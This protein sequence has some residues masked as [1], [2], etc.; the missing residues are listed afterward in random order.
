MKQL[1]FL[2]P[3]FK[4]H[5]ITEALN[6][7][8]SNY[9]QLAKFL[10]R[11]TLCT[12]QN[13]G[14]S[15]EQ[16]LQNLLGLEEASFPQAALEGLYQKKIQ[17]ED[18]V[19]YISADFVRFNADANHVFLE[20]A[21]NTS[22]EVVTLI[23]TLCD[24]VLTLVYES[25]YRC[26][27]RVNQILDVLFN[28]IWE[29]VGRSLH[30]RLP[31]GPDAGLINRLS[32]E[33]QMGLQ[34]LTQDNVTGVWF[35]GHGILPSKYTVRYDHIVSNIPALG[36]LAQCALASYANLNPD[37][38]LENLLEKYSDILIVDTCDTQDPYLEYLEKVYIIK[39]LELLA[40]KK[41]DKVVL[42]MGD[43]KFYTL[44]ATA[45]RCYFWRLTKPLES[46]C[47]S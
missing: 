6:T 13:R 17:V 27:F 35:W 5:S 7:Q 25:K 4:A 3:G 39:S 43:G 42:C 40:H 22:S 21:I 26:I 8:D 9:P 28:P 31:S 41:C 38:N 15:F 23:Q 45:L 18:Q 2:V 20:P 12:N 16:V 29:V 32:T 33:I 14:R 19:H 34:S 44:T 10:S 36:G 47:E 46:F 30:A 11:S 24:P 37:I 1:T